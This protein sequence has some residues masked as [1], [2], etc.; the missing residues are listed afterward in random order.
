M[1]KV[2]RTSLYRDPYDN[3]PIT[4]VSRAIDLRKPAEEVA[5]EMER[6]SPGVFV[7][8]EV[9]EVDEATYADPLKVPLAAV[10]RLKECSPRL[11][12]E[13]DM[14]M[15]Y[16]WNANALKVTTDHG[17]ISA[18]KPAPLTRDQLQTVLRQIARHPEY[19]H[20]NVIQFTHEGEPV[21]LV[22]GKIS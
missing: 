9:F 4:I 1:Y 6:S 17:M 7:V 5:R 18:T 16:Y 10:R 14:A 8:S 22:D 13:L 20:Q 19:K 11:Q 2:I 12:G 21:R 3:T 15:C